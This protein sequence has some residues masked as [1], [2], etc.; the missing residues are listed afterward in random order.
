MECIQ[1][2]AVPTISLE[3]GI[4]EDWKREFKR[5]GNIPDARRGKAQQPV[6][7]LRQAA[8]GIISS[9]PLNKIDVYMHCIKSSS[10]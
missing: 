4:S 1:H 8:V 2:L 9:E 3:A 7:E 5:N 6:A 10:A